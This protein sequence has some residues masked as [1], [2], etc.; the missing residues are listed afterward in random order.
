MKIIEPGSLPE[1]KVHRLR[2]NNCKCLFEF[3]QSEGTIGSE[4]NE[5]YVMIHCPIC[6]NEV[7]HYI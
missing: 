6:K 2:C 5:S 7:Y 3:K 4:R 1:E